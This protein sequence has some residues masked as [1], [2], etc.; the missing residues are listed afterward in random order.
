MRANELCAWFGV[1]PSTGGNKAKQ[2]RD[3][4]RITQFDPRWTLPS[5]IDQ[6]PLMWMISA[7]GL[8]VDARAMPPS[9]QEE[10]FRR[11]LIPYVPEDSGPEV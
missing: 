1:A 10:A 4:L 6:N 9:L 8:I 5:M 3:M 11:G 2:I 7:N